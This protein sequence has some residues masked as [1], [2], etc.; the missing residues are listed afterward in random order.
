[1]LPLVEMFID[2]EATLRLA[3]RAGLEPVASDTRSPLSPL[4][5]A[6]FEFLL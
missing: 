3:L 1:M 6:L 2:T 4:C 5:D